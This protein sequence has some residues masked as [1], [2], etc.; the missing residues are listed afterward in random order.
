M[1]FIGQFKERFGESYPSIHDLI[2]EEPIEKK[3]AVLSHLINAPVVAAAPCIACD[4][5]TGE[6]ISGG[7]LL[8]YCDGE[9]HWQSDLIHYFEKHNFKLPQDFIDRAISWKMT[10]SKEA[11]EEEVLERCEKYRAYREAIKDET[12][13]LCPLVDERIGGFDCMENQ[14]IRDESIPD[15]FKSKPDWKSICK[16]C[17]HRDYWE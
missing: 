10:K 7:S 3:E 17:E 6:Y 16:K 15:R 9:Y 14:T 11:W 13:A 12:T 5:I 2:S 4:V 8:A 1:I